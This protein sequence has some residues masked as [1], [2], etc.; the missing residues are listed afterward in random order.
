MTNESPRPGP[1]QRS[2]GL[3]KTESHIGYYPSELSKYM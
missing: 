2:D 3:K 1:A